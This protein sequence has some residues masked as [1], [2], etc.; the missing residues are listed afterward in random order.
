RPTGPLAF[1]QHEAA[2]GVVLM[3]A[4]ALA[5]VLQNSPA[6]HV[7]DA[8]IE[9]PVSFRVDAL[10]LGK[11][12]LHWINDGLMAGFFFFVGVA[13]KRG[14]GWVG[15]PGPGKGRPCGSWGGGGAGGCRRSSMALSTGAMPSRG[16]AGP[17]PPR[18]TSPSPS[19]CWRC[20][21]RAFPPRSRCSSSRSPSS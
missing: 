19:A 17:S 6:S 9:T 3:A 1:L 5:L 10:E 21:A 11:P 18:P 7:Y 13:S 12:L 20:W 4:A 14:L 8:L 16:E 15:A 2:G